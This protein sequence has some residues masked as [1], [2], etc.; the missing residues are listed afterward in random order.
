[1]TTRT[2]LR[3]QLVAGALLCVAGVTTPRPAAAQRTAPGAP[4]RLVATPLLLPDGPQRVGMDYLAF[5]PATSRVWVPAGNTGRVDVV[6]AKTKTV[7]AIE[8]FPTKTVGDRTQGT[9]S[10][11]VGAGFVYV[12]NR[13]NDQVC[14]ID[15]TTL[16]L[17]GCVALQSSPDGLAYVAATQEVWVTTPRATSL[18]IL[19]VSV[20]GA[21]KA[22]AVVALDGK[23]E[24]YGVDAVAGRFYTNLEDKNLTLAFDVKTR[25]EVARFSPGCGTQGPRGLA[26]D[27]ARQLLL[28]ACT[29]RVVS[30]NLAQNGKRLS[31]IV[32]GEGVDN[33]DYAPALHR[34]YAASGK[35]STLTIA[36][37]QNDGTF[38]LHATAPTAAGA[39]VVVVDT[40]GT[41]FVADS[42]GGRLLVVTD[43]PSLSGN[44][45]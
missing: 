42:G 14:A 6:D 5:D 26:L 2:Y 32:T 27:T 8:G 30:L 40:T 4:R 21:P 12:G 16:K 13:A 31:E 34:V 29:D 43:A 10:A 1:M 39:R 28:V 18:T 41:A 15:S 23:P 37:V 7:T 3:S 22:K 19:D 36:E 20:P 24:G 38:V 45:K 9:S 44:A 11:T 35:T 33:I 17:A 25:K